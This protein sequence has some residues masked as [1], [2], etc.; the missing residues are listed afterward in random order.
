MNSAQGLQ[1]P[2]AQG[3]RG[4][5]HMGRYLIQ[6]RFHSTKANRHETRD[7][8]KDDSKRGAKQYRSHWNPKTLF[9]E[10]T[11]HSIERRK[12]HDDPNRQ[13]CARDGISDRC[14]T[15]QNT[16]GL[17]TAETHAIGHEQADHDRTNRRRAR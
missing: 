2:L 13:H 7:I 1:R 15:G 11:D 14:Q 4:I 8:G 5:I 10:A 6:G 9:N 3:A 17:S 16:Q 12:G